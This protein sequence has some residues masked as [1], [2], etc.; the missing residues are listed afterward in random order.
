[1]SHASYCRMLYAVKTMPLFLFKQLV[2]TDSMEYDLIRRKKRMQS[3]G[4][5]VSLHK[6]HC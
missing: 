2:L 3:N 6:Y 5:H 4:V 1:M